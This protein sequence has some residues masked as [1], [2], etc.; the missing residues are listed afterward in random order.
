MKKYDESVRNPH[1]KTKEGDTVLY[2]FSPPLF[3]T[4][5]D[6]SFTNDLIEEGRKLQNKD[7]Y[8]E[9]LA[10]NLKNGGSYHYHKPFV[11]KSEKYLSNYVMRFVNGISDHYDTDYYLKRFLKIYNNNTESYDIGTIKLDS[12]WI[13]FQKNYDFNP[14][15][16]HGGALSFVVFC[17]VP[18]KI[19]EVQANSNFQHAG[20]IVFEYGQD[21]SELMVS[22]FCY[23]PE[24]NDLFIFPSHLKHFVPP[25]WVDEERISVS[26]NFVV[27]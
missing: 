25:F 9:N 11:K 2:P 18:P 20:S 4:K 22:S 13:N 10:G 26:G 6:S 19:F 7:N 8:S 16:T 15:H 21:I 5:V 24:I 23:K 1:F 14:P 27:V 12:L 3:K 17:K